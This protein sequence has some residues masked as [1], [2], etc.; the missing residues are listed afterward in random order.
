MPEKLKYLFSKRMVPDI[1]DRG[2]QPAVSEMADLIDIPLFDE[3]C[4]H[5]KCE[6]AARSKTEYSGDKIFPGRNPECK[7]SGKTFCTV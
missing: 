5:M 2:Y 3:L 7:K 1:E 4:R 6:Y